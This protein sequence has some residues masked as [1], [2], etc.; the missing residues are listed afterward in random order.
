VRSDFPGGWAGDE[1]NGFT[2][3]GMSE[4]ELAAQDYLRRLLNWRQDQSAIHTGR[5]LHF[6]PVDGVYVYFRYDET[7]T[8]MVAINHTENEKRIDVERYREGI[9]EHQR[10]L[11][12]IEGTEQALTDELTLPPMGATIFNLK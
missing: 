4:Q 1:R 12:V 7:Q 10:A 6:A 9:G 5:L 3:E 8:I 2:G 11:D